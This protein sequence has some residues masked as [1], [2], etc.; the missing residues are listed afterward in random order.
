MVKKHTLPPEDLDLKD[1]LHEER[2][3]FEE[4]EVPIVTVSATFRK[5]LADKYRS[6]VHTP[7]EVV[8][9]RAHYSMAEAVR[10]QA[11]IL[12]K[13]AFISDPTNF[14]S[15]KDWGKIEFTEKIGKTIARYKILK[16]VKDKLNDLLRGSTP[17][18]EAIKSPLLYLTG[19]TPCPIISMHYETGNILI[20][21]GKTVI[22]AVTDPYVHQQYLDA[23]PSPNVTY[24]VFDE[25]TKGSLLQKAGDLKRELT[26]DQVVVTGVFV[27][28]R[29][30][31]TGKEA[32]K[33]SKDEPINLAVTTGGLGTNLNE[34]KKV[35]QAFKPLLVPPERIR[36]FLYAGTHKDFRRFF[37]DFARENHV[38]VGNLDDTDARIRILY[39]DSII[40]ANE[41]LIKYMFPWAHGV[42]AKPSGDMAYDAAAAGCFLLFL[43]PWGIWEEKIQQIFV[44]KRVGFNLDTN[45]SYRHFIKLLKSGQLEKALA[46]AHTLPGLFREGCKNIIELHSTK[47]CLIHG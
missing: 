20:K 3:L 40:D 47:P 9:S 22:Q 18:A 37:E 39:D 8:F 10:R 1:A 24:A 5:E 34:I 46:N 29:I 25:E 26:D 38:R 45:N 42:I 30:I 19:K 44:N 35:L 33:I 27:D 23:I 32:K 11:N 14:V 12:G 2:H 31:E 41:N 21:S 13:K 28:P 16:M 6:V 17:I 4:A 15:K 7:S 36:L 43:E